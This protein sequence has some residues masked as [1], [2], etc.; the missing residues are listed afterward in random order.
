MDGLERPARSFRR[1]VKEAGLQLDD[2]RVSIVET[3][4]V[5]RRSCGARR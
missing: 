4:L 5:V 3:E 2:R 1:A